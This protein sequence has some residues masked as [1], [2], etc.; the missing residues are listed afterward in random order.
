MG[1]KQS[2][3][4]VY[5]LQSMPADPALPRPAP[6]FLK[7]CHATFGNLPRPARST[8][9]ASDR[10]KAS[11]IT[12]PYEP[13][14]AD[15]AEWEAQA[16]LQRQKGEA[17]ARSLALGAS[18]VE[19]P[20]PDNQH[21]RTLSLREEIIGSWNKFEA[22]MGKR[23]KT[24]LGGARELARDWDGR[25][26]LREKMVDEEGARVM[27]Q[28]VAEWEVEVELQWWKARERSKA[29]FPAMRQG[30]GTERPR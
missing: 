9:L 2:T 17:R 8:G 4:Q 21:L 25:K 30:W 24:W 15:V 16:I 5:E 13:R 10:N 28:D 12:R 19:V 18:E 6:P 11:L 26:V 1:Q 27:A 7:S 20:V 29:E 22:M 3:E 14:Q 23:P